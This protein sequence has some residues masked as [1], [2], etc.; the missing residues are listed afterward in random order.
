MAS[1]GCDTRTAE[2]DLKMKVL[3]RE[4]QSQR[5]TEEDSWSP[6]VP[7]LKS[8]LLMGFLLCKIKILW[9]VC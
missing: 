1:F 5:H 3:G 4:E 9:S 2:S 7:P 6:Q 8:V